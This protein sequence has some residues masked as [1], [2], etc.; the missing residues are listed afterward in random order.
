[1]LM[2][3]F[4]AGASYDSVSEE[5]MKS[6]PLEYRPPLARDLFE[7]RVPFSHALTQYPYIS[8]VVGRLRRL[9]RTGGTLEENLETLKVEGAAHEPTQWALNAMRFYLRDIIRDCGRVWQSESRGGTHYAEMVRRLD[10]WR[11]SHEGPVIFVTF[12][13]DTL[14][15]GALRFSLNV[16]LNRTDQRDPGLS[17]YVSGSN[18]QLFKLHGSIDWE[19]AVPYGTFLLSSM[20]EVTNELLIRRPNIVLTDAYAYFGQFWGE[21]V[22]AYP[23]IAVPTQNKSDSDFACPKL[24]QQTLVETLPKVTKLISIGWRGAERHFLDL[25]SERMTSVQ[26]AWVVAESIDSANEAV[27]HLGRVGVVATPLGGGFSEFI[28]QDGLTNCLYR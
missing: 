1:M 13:Y 16:A 7:N 28:E 10:I 17:T 19:V 4:G 18:Y 9:G 8:S 26:D 2:V 25:M 11:V 24:H 14:L 6:M 20:E 23:A 21:K 22:V 5:T 27:K 12:N 3:I 15:E